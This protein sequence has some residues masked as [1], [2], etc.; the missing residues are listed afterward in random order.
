MFWKN[1]M[2]SI[3]AVFVR[4]NKCKYIFARAEIAVA[5]LD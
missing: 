4:L 3:A 2:D 1:S 5:V